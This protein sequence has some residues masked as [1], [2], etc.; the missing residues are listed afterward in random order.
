MFI[1]K[2]LIPRELL[3]T[4]SLPGCPQFLTAD[5]AFAITDV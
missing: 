1:K 2:P 5:K 4:P 3:P